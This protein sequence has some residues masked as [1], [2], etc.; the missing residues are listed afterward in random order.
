MKYVPFLFCKPWLNSTRRAISMEGAEEAYLRGSWLYFGLLRP[1]V[2]FLPL[3]EDPA[4][5][6]TVPSSTT[7]LLFSW[8]LPGQRKERK[9]V[10]RDLHTQKTFNKSPELCFLHCVQ[11]N[12]HKMRICSLQNTT[13]IS[14]SC[15]V[16]INWLSLPKAKLGVHKQTFTIT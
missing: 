12:T 7:S 5:T 13:A 1:T 9:G 16:Y 6:D 10:A 2:V 3:F 15:T 8:P 11:R 14:F 4:N